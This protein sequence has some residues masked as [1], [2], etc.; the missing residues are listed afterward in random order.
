MLRAFVRTLP[1]S[2]AAHA[3]SGD[4]MVARIGLLAAYPQAYGR[5]PNRVMAKA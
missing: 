4:C 1:M 2:A 3:A 5:L